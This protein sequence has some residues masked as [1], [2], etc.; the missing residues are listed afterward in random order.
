MSCH[1]GP[2]AI[3]DNM[4]LIIDPG[5]TRSYPGTGTSVYD[6]SGND[7]TCTM[8]GST[9]VQDS[10]FYVSTT[11][12]ITSPLDGPTTFLPT[13][14]FT[15]STWLMF[16]SYTDVSDANGTILGSMNFDGYG[17]YWRGTTSSF[18]VGAQMRAR[19]GGGITTLE[20]NVNKD[21]WMNLTMVYSYSDNFIKLFINGVQ[22]STT[23]A[24]TGGT[25]ELLAGRNISLNQSWASAGAVSVRRFI[26]QISLSAIYT[27]AL[28]NSEVTQNF[29]AFRSRFG[30]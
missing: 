6:L 3:E 1:A 5:N 27:T 23:T 22:H 2:N 13:S 30:L 7:N 8:E 19:I 18:I 16:T 15:L 25:Y 21:E 9:Y 17:L 11:D 28:S 26:G 12:Y 29:Q 14:N 20:A 4:L 10:V 24:L